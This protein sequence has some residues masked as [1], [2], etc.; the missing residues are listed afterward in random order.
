MRHFD[1]FDLLFQLIDGLELHGDH[2]CGLQRQR[3]E[4][5]LQIGATFHA[6]EITDGI[7]L[8]TIAVDACVDAVLECGAQIAQGHACTQQFALVAQLAGRN[9]AL[10]QR[11]AAQENGQ[12]LGVEGIG[13]VAL[14]HAPLGLEGVGQ[15]RMMPSFFHGVDDPVPVSGGFESNFAAFR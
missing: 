5:A 15:V 9:P 3:L 2:L 7:G 6:E 1:G 13:L 4:N 11:A 14:G 10:G 12:T 8:Q